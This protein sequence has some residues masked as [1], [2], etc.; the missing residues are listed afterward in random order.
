MKS[1]F[2]LF[3][4]L[5]SYIIAQDFEETFRIENAK[6]VADVRQTR[7]EILK[8]SR[9]ESNPWEG[10]Y[11]GN[12]GADTFTS[13]FVSVKHG[14]ATLEHGIFGVHAG[15]CGVIVVNDSELSVSL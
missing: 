12:S 13:I 14:I 9:S 3:F 5:Q 8:H 15:N 11:L 10:E 1:F 7:K 2:L 6:L 4:L